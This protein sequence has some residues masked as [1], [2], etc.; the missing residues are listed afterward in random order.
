MYPPRFVFLVLFLVSSHSFSADRP[1][2]PAECSVV[3]AGNEA[4]VSWVAANKDNAERYVIRRK[5]DDGEWY[6]AGAVF[7]GTSF[8]NR[9]LKSN[10]TYKYT[11]ETKSADGDFSGV[12]PCQDLTTPEPPVVDLAPLEP[13]DGVLF[14]AWPRSSSTNLNNG[15]PAVADFEAAT[16]SSMDIVQTFNPPHQPKFNIEYINWILAQNKIPLITWKVGPDEWPTSGDNIGQRVVN[17]EFDAQIRERAA[18]AR[19]LNGPFFSRLFHE[20]DGQYGRSYDLTPELFE[21]YWRRVRDI[22]AEEGVTNAVWV[23]TPAAFAASEAG[24]YPGDDVVDWIGVDPYLWI[25]DAGASRC[26][27][28]NVQYQPLATR[29]GTDFWEFADKHPSKPIMLAEWGSGWQADS[30]IREN[31]ISSAADAIKQ[32]P[33]LKALV[34]FNSSPDAG[35]HWTL[36]EGVDPQKGLKAYSDLANSPEYEVD[37][38]SLINTFWQKQQ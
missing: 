4:S 3:R 26:R 12:R 6:W 21:K 13:A 32:H 28:T 24:W 19:Q 7:S 14:G 37:I 22:F 16:N 30:A 38:P 1:L 18:E 25:G 2:A 11:V 10:S 34:Y 9:N 31:F 8:V 17:G 23:W 35:C 29:V 20:M 15:V 27:N 33:K 5:R 36:T